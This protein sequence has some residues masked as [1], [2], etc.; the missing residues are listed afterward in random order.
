MKVGT[1]SLSHSGRAVKQM[2]FEK[3]TKAE[4]QAEKKGK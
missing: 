2:S 4:T 3:V 1:E